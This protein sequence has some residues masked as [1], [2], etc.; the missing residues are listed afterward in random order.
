MYQRIL[1]AILISGALAGSA[2][3]QSSKVDVP[4][5]E[6]IA[7][8]GAV[9]IGIHCSYPPAG[10]V[11]LDGQPSGYEITIAKEIA[12]Y[13]NAKLETQCVTEGNRIPFLQSGKIDFILASLAYTPARAEQVA[14]S[15]PIWVSNLQ[16]VVPKDSKISGYDDLKGKSVATPT[17]STYQTWLEKCYPQ[18]KVVPAQNAAELATM[19][20]QGRVDAFAYIDIYDYNFA[21]MHPEYKVVGDLAASAIQGVGVKKAN[22]ELLTWVNAVIDDLRKHDAFY[23]AFADEVKDEDFLKKYRKAVPGPDVTLD[24]SKSGSL[25]CLK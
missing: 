2:F 19:L 18:A 14:Y 21:R 10:Y 8:R 24:Y 25:D 6:T 16:L 17:G 20:S 7:S 13:A 9:T 5:P 23:K 4:V 1:S 3:A 12:G 22:K 11:G 15:D